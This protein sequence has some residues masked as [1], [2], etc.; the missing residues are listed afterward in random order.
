MMQLAPNGK[1][2]MTTGSGTD[3]LHVINEPDLGGQECL[4]QQHQI[5]LPCYYDFAPPHFPYFRLGAA[6]GVQRIGSGAV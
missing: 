4:F 6:L 1:I 3:R 2:Y 5:Q